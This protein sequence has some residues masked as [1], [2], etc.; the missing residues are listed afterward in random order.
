M[1]R[2]RTGKRRLLIAALSVASLPILLFTILAGRAL[3]LRSRQISSH[4]QLVGVNPSRVAS[5]LS[6]AVQI[7]TI[8]TEDGHED[9]AEFL[10]FHQWLL[11]SY[12]R[13]HSALDRET[14]NDLSLLYKWPGKEPSLRPVLLAA[15]MDVVPV[16]EGSEAGWR[17]PPFG[18]R[19][20]GGEI[21]GR[22]A[23]DD[24]GSLVAI[25]EAIESLLEN[26]FEPR[27]SIYIALGHD[28]EV[29]GT[30][31]AR[32]ISELLARRGVK[33]ELVLDEGGAV[34]HGL[35]PAASGAV[36]AVA[37]AEKSV[38]NIELTI[39]AAGGH[40]SAPA[41]ETAIG[42]LSRAISR[43]EA[44]PMPARLAPPVRATLEYIAPEAP[45]PQRMLMGNL[46]ASEWILRRMMQA[47][48]SGNAQV[49]TTCVTTIFQAG[50][51]SNVIPASARAVVDCRILPGDTVA[52]VVEHLRRAVADD[53]V[54]V[55]ARENG[56]DPPPVSTFDSA[57][58][59]LLKRA[60]AATF[61]DTPSAPVMTT[62]ATDARHYAKL[63]ESVYRF[64]PF[65]AT[66]ETFRIVHGTDE[67]VSI[68]DSQ[69]AVQFYAQLLSIA[70]R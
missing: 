23:F 26:N 11:A 70:A 38:A 51:K 12:P 46:W 36:A 30:R 64:I 68:K 9:P 60:I 5:R 4:E 66:P 24:K 2:S 35:L 1:A 14:I 42:I 43:I 52:S 63:S 54:H 45:L 58:A 55:T 34:A 39:A 17:Y 13:V 15:H 49:R 27:R 56:A 41:R 67:R 19:I 57:G 47:T 32:A 18:G 22:G 33:P 69:R 37:V 65:P 6:E 44:N 48:P 28:E 40:S 16:P 8:S 21:W 50:T 29:G 59:L 7:R 31:G 20:D 53:S 10:R 25:M 61:P 62:G 3:T